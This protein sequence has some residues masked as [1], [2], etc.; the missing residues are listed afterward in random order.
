M[1]LDAYASLLRMSAG[2]PISTS[3]AAARLRVSHSSASHT[4]GKLS[5]RGFA[6]RIRPGLW[7][8]GEA[9]P[10]RFAIV[11]SLTAPAPSYV[12]FASAL[13]YYGLID[14]LPRQ[15]TVASTGRPHT[16]KTALGE[17]VVHRIPPELFDGW[18]NE[19]GSPVA[20]PEK[21]LFDLAYVAAVR[22][23]PAFAPELDLPPDFS[24]SR[25]ERWIESIGAARLRTLTRQ[26]LERLL[27]RA[28]R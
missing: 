8:L 15:T 20:I 17:Y 2:E 28:T 5:D 21:A 25:F 27:A 23:R 12:S 26:E 9:A 7:A 22:G 13:N 10:D 3:E 14:Q 19:R 18:V 11:P 24:A 1:I 6:Q 16:I 4:L